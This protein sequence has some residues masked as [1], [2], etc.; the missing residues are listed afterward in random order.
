MNAFALAALLAL[1]LP[2]A[3]DSPRLAV[4]IAVADGETLCT[5]TSHNAPLYDVVR[6]IAERAD[7]ELDGF[8]GDWQ[9]LLVSADLRR[10]PLRQVLSYL[11]G[12]VDLEVEIRQGALYV[13]PTPQ[14]P[15]TGEL[16]ERAVAAYQRTLRDFPDHPQS[17]RVLRELA[18]IE[19]HRGSIGAARAR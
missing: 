7:L 2:S 12:S 4:E 15:Q 16:L 14:D 17:A 10:R 3:D 6:E 8:R 5:V 1:Q 19:Q 9:R 18:E 13:R 11:L